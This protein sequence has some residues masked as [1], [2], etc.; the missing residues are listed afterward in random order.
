ML[1]IHEVQFEM[2]NEHVKQGL[3]QDTQLPPTRNLV[4]S[5][6]LVQKAVELQAKQGETQG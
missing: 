1:V 5:T 6:Q 3:L 2:L 4:E